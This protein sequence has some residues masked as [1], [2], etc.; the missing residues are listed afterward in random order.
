MTAQLGLD[1][2]EVPYPVRRPTPLTDR[3]REI[4]AYVRLHGVVR[5]V[6]VGRMMHFGRKHPHGAVLLL[7]PAPLGCCEHASSDGC[8]ALRRLERRGLVRRV[9]RG[10]WV[11]ER[12]E[13]GWA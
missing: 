12:H 10:Q 5:P 2:T 8:G 11:P 3:Q 9:A 13:E 7:P 4:L 1:G 6:E